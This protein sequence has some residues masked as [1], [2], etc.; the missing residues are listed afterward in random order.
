MRLTCLVI[1]SLLATTTTSPPQLRAGPRDQTSVSASAGIPDL[2]A[3]E[4]RPGPAH[5][6][7]LVVPRRDAEH[8]APDSRGPLQQPGV[9]RRPPGGVSPGGAAGRPGPTIHDVAGGPDAPEGVDHVTFTAA[10]LD[11]AEALLCVDVARVYATG[12]SQGGGFI[13]ARLAC[14][15][16][17]SGRIA[18]F[19]PVPGTFYN[20]SVDR[21]SSCDPLHLE[22]ACEAPRT[23]TENG[24][25]TPVLELHGGADDVI[26]FH[27]GFR[28]ARA[29]RPSATG[30]RT[31]RG[32]TAR[33]WRDDIVPVGGTRNGVQYVYGD[34]LVVLVYAGDDVEHIWMSR[35]AGNADL[36]ASA[37]I[38]DFL[39]STTWT[40]KRLACAAE[41]GS[42]Q[43]PDAPPGA[44]EVVIGA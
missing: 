30:P 27:G 41:R 6:P 23:R 8:R 1:T 22:N 28:R 40:R 3:A 31:G 12:H 17:T 4:L 26:S 19:V 44:L 39:G 43:M 13:E 33:T 24:S 29:G 15:A 7:D 36:D 32:G 14:D 5:A 16:A 42:R 35:D 11:A 38:I 25:R 9:Q 2:A 21:A 37:W 18:T 20:A 10:V 34:G